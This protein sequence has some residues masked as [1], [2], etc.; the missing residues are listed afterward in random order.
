MKFYFFIL[1]GLFLCNLLHATTDI[2]ITKTNIATIL[3]QKNP[4]ALPHFYDFC[5]K[6]DQL[7]ENFLDINNNDSLATHVGYISTATQILKKLC[8][9]PEFIAV[10]PILLDYYK[11]ATKLVS[12]LQKYIGSRN[13]LFFGLQLHPFRFLLPTAVKNKG[14]LAVLKALNHRLTVS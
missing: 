4:A 14:R 12:L 3:Q 10:K 1:T 11:Q 13:T 6:Y 7:V 2:E 8:Y 9:N 5:T